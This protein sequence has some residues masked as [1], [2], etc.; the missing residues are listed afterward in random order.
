MV[1]GPDQLHASKKVMIRIRKTIAEQKSG[2]L[3]NM[4][5]YSYF[6]FV[7]TKLFFCV[8]FVQAS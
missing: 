1:F 5:D 2:K 8:L 6:Y 4:I 3:E 7:A